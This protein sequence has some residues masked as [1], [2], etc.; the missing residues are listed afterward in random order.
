MTPEER[1]R[2]PELQFGHRRHGP[3]ID[4]QQIDP[5]KAVQELAMAAVGA[6]HSQIS[7][8]FR[9]LQEKRRVAVR[10]AFCANAR[11]NQVFPMPVGPIRNRCWCSRTQADSAASERT[12]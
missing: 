9:R 8:Q 7:E 6:R 3:V 4:N 12:S 2:R 5:P 11:P 1:R 10:Q